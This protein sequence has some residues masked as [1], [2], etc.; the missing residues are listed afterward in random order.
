MITGELEPSS[1]TIFFKPAFF[2]IIFA[3]STPPVKLINLMLSSLMS[4]SPK[5]SGEP[6]IMLNISFGKPA[7]ERISPNLMAI[8]GV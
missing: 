7:S 8:K 6:V 5:Y 1:I 2:W 4:A 3:A